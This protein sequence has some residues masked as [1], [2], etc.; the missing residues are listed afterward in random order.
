MVV[1]EGSESFTAFDQLKGKTLVLP[2]GYASMTLVK[3]QYPDIKLIEVR[4][5]PDALAALLAGR[6]DA[7]VLPLLVA[8][9][10][11]ARF[12]EHRLRVSMTLSDP[13]RSTWVKS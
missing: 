13:L 5:V 11:I 9:Y 12:Y 6:A 7:T 2:Q 8:R 3:E 4:D 10:Y 1:R